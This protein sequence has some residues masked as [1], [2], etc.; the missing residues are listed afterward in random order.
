MQ[1][2][3]TRRLVRLDAR[4]GTRLF[5]RRPGVAER[6]RR[7]TGCRQAFERHRS[8]QSHYLK[9]AGDNQTPCALPQSKKHAKRRT[10]SVA[11]CPCSC[12]TASRQHAS[13]HTRKI[14]KERCAKRASISC[15]NA[16][17]YK[18]AV[19]VDV[20]RFPAQNVN[21]EDCTPKH[22]CNP[23]MFVSL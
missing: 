2:K 4:D 23:T 10:A 8:A 6:S 22:K 11:P 17:A 16:A 15:A 14:C 7:Y 20:V 9:T 1:P 3:R 13:D 19:G 18:R 12:L 5:G 21:E